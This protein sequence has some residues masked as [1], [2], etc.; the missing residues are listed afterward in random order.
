MLSMTGAKVY[1][2]LL[3]Y[4]V[5][6]MLPRLLGSPELFGLYSSAMSI[7]SILTN[8]LVVATIQTV[9]KQVSESA[10]RE[11]P[12]L[13]QGLEVQ[14]VVG[15]V[16][17]AG[18][19]LAA[20]GLA[21][22]KGDPR[23]VPLFRVASIVMLSYALY[24]A[25]VGSLNG[26]KRF[27]HQAALDV[28]YSTL[29]TAGL[30]GAAALGLGPLGC[31]TGFA[32]AASTVLLIALFV[33]GL[34]RPGD[35]IP[36]AKWLTFMA[37]LWLYH[38][39]L[40]L[41]LQF[42]LFLVSSSVTHMSVDAGM[43]AQAASELGNRYAGF[44][45]AAQTFAFVPY[46]LILSVAFVI[47][48]MVSSAVSLGDQAQARSYI[49]NALRFSLIV[50]LAIAAPVSGAADGV[51]RL[52]YQPEY[53]AGSQALS[54]L[55]PGMACFALFVIGATILSGA[56]MPGRAAAIAGVSVVTVTV[57]NL[58]LVRWVGVGEH[59][60]V[61]AAVGTSI[62]T[63]LALVAIAIAVHRRFGAFIPALCVVRVVLGAGVGF[64]V[65][66]FVPHD[67][68]IGALSALISGGLAY[69]AALFALR[70]LGRADLD[71]VLSVLGRRR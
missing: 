16:L 12:A 57:C 21:W 6:L 64:L 62:G 7:V 38:L 23:V 33:V 37:P 61:A 65:A 3:G 25:L 67:T 19:L 63:T 43:A 45:R 36:W 69:L 26:R 48:P 14:L 9:S 34:G 59:T 70:E 27:H 10:D 29:R 71:A 13:R 47:F 60:L 49:T 66:R 31:F 28:T 32:G 51:M 4:S 54:V 41:I 44:Y 58:V 11:A 30:L 35:R 39:F 55:A 22:V 15:V 17:A 2:I 42:D 18:L 52:A 53:L 5:Q 8:L 20:P 46:Q 1:F 56:G 50:L 40:N 24:A 68:A